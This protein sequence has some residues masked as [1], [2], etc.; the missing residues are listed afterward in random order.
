MLYEQLGK[1]ANLRKIKLAEAWELVRILTLTHLMFPSVLSYYPLELPTYPN[2]DKKIATVQYSQRQ[3]TVPE[4]S[5][6]IN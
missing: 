3:Y 4:Y 2:A 6:T 5:T 1:K